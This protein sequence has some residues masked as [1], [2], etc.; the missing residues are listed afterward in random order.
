MCGHRPGRKSLGRRGSCTRDPEEVP[1]VGDRTPGGRT[2][3]TLNRRGRSTDGRVV[4]SVSHPKC[5]GTTL[6]TSS[7]SA[8][9]VGTGSTDR[10]RHPPSPW[11]CVPPSPSVLLLPG[12]APVLL[13]L[14]TG[15]APTLNTKTPSP[16]HFLV[17]S[18][19][20]V[21]SHL[22]R[23]LSSFCLVPLRF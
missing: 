9:L 2:V 4:P 5:N 20:L 15:L 14:S 19:T 13:S 12:R 16:I 7:P 8:P 11:F 1:P 23:F 21:C 17:S 22:Y 6:G 3:R 10:R 18:S